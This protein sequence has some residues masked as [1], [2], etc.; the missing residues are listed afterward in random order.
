MPFECEAMGTKNIITLMGAIGKKFSEFS[1]T[2]GTLNLVPHQKKR[3]KHTEHI[4]QSD[5]P[6]T[7]NCPQ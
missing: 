1:F 4:T 7:W 2:N 6:W 3:G 5:Q